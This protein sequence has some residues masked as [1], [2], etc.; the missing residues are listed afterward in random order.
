[1]FSIGKSSQIGRFWVRIPDRERHEGLP[2][3]SRDDLKPYFSKAHIKP[4]ENYDRDFNSALQ[5]G[6]LHEDDADSYITTKG[7]EAVE[8]NFE[9]ERSYSSRASNGQ[10]YKAGKMRT[11]RKP[12]A[13]SQ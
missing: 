13:K 12:M 8:A 2:R 1:M 7:I 10:K 5:K 6:W 11:G 4:P 9:G 3:F